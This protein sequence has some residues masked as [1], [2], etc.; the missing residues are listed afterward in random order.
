M[1]NNNT[2]YYEKFSSCEKLAYDDDNELYCSRCSN[3][4]FFTK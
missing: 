1:E 4:Y 2:E 3:Q